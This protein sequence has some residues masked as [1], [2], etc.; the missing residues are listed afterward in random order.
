MVGIGEDEMEQDM[1]WRVSGVP[2]WLRGNGTGQS[3]LRG[4]VRA[5]IPCALPDVSN[6]ACNSPVDRYI[7]V[8]VRGSAT[9]Y[10]TVPKSERERERER[11]T[12]LPCT[13][14]FTVSGIYFGDGFGY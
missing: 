3:A 7:P 8:P 4:Q 13:G 11:F 10:N 2:L 6:N 1:H 12:P 14:Y 5:Y 9:R